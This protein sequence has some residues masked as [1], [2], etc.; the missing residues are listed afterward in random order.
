MAVL[1]VLSVNVVAG[2]RVGV[3]VEEDRA[4]DAPF[5]HVVA[6]QAGDQVVAA[7][8]QQGVVARV[9]DDRVVVGAA[10]DV[11]DPHRVG[12]GQVE[13]ARDHGLGTGLAQVDRDAVGSG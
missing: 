8:A 7:A 13:D 5:D 6:A 9:A 11:G 4:C 3:E 1:L 12:K 2:H 10:Q